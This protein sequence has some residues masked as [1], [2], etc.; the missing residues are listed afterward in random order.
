MNKESKFSKEKEMGMKCYKCF[1]DL[2]G[3]SKCPVCGYD[4]QEDKS[5]F[6]AIKPGMKLHN[7]RYLVGVSVGTGGFGVTYA[8]WDN[9]L[10]TRVA[11]KEYLPGE[12]STRL[13]GFTK[14]TSY[15]GEKAEQFKDGLQKFYE[16]SVRLAKFR[17]VKGIVQIFDSFFENDTG[18]IVMEYLQGETLAE[19]LKRVERIPAE[20]AV[21][22]VLP[23]L[24]ALDKVHK[25]GILHRDI[26]PNNIFLCSDG[27]VK[28][29]DFG[30]ARGATGTHSKSL[31]V[32]Y[33]EGYTAEEQY[34]SNGNQGPWTDVYA[35]A[36]TLYKMITGEKPDGAMERR[37]K[38]LIKE[39]AK[40]KGVKV[41]TN[42]NRAI[43]N[44]LNI[45]IAKRTQSA[46]QFAQELSLD[47]KVESR[48]VRT[49]EK[50]EG[51]IPKWMLGLSGGILTIAAVF[52]ILL[53]TGVIEFRVEKFMNLFVDENKA[54]IM[55]LVN[56]EE[57]E[58]R[59]RI[60][61]LGLKLEVVELKY[62]NKVEAN[63][64]ISQEEEKG[65][66]LD[67]GATVHV[68]VSR[69]AGVVEIP[70][71][72]GRKWDSV[73]GTLE[74]LCL[75][76]EV[77]EEKSIEAPGYILLLNP[78]SGTEIEQGQTVAV[79]V[80]A[81]MDYDSAKV[82]TVG[83]Y[84]G[85]AY[86]EIKQE[87]ANEGIYLVVNELV[88]DE[89]VS[90]DCIAWQNT[91]ENSEINGGSIIVVDVSRG[92]TPRIVPGMVGMNVD[93][94][95]R[96]LQ[97]LG[98]VA[99]VKKVV[100]LDAEEG[101]VLKQSIAE[102]EEVAKETRIELTVASRGVEEQLASGQSYFSKTQYVQA[103]DAY[104]KALATEPSNIAAYEGVINSYIGLGDRDKALEYAEEGYAKTGAASIK[105]LLDSL[106]VESD[107]AVVDDG[108]S[109]GSDDD[110]DDDDDDDDS[111]T[112]AFW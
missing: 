15:G 48:F 13:P 92:A 41:P 66:I 12:F 22:I 34:R 33:K 45:D 61:A 63:R 75:E 6:Y 91:Q 35:L 84:V 64:I 60:E 20:E 69:G 94:A 65:S 100:N 83:D 44:A 87:L 57:G 95:K 80:S 70:E 109:E 99:V 2:N 96:Q 40:Y 43:M 23:V 29:L 111:W 110:N 93:V 72:V 82:V 71:L 8:A 101:V 76:Y 32:L 73:K 26:A 7:G 108:G 24:D 102:N 36:A 28:L 67:K 25:K 107:S 112:P 21:K 31:T 11:I 85:K 3:E 81:G 14:V 90:Q 89:T 4:Y 55:N 49:S 5:E 30:A 47:K 54:R 56:M 62:S 38:D 52:T 18:Y 97:E 104:Q 42:V 16:E 37:R 79:T 88:Y 58:G 39:P 10:Q 77:T 46:A 19:Y 106:K 105:A 27:Q 98:L 50:K 86:E 1:S 17:E 51:R 9:V 103:L 78:E 59:E 53:F 68:V 74:D